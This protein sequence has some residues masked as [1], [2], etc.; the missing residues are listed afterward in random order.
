MKR[1]INKFKNKIYSYTEDPYKIR[2]NL[3]TLKSI[4][5]EAGLTKPDVYRSCT[6]DI[7]INGEIIDPNGGSPEAEVESVYEF[8]QWLKNKS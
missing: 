8:C 1:I 6:D 2:L 3:R 5:I 4:A 7:I